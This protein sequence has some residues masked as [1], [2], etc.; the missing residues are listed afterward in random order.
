MKST[1]V[2]WLPIWR[3][4]ND[5]EKLIFNYLF[6]LSANPYFIKQLLGRNNNARDATWIIECTIKDLVRRSLFR[7]Y[8]FSVCCQYNR[9]IFDLNK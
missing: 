2:Y 6:T 1:S 3:I 9:R 8:L 7:L 5:I 4:S